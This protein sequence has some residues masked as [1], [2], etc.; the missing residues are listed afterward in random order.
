[1]N[2]APPSRIYNS[3]KV[4]KPPT[5]GVPLDGAENAKNT[6]GMYVSGGSQIG[7]KFKSI[8]NIYGD[9]ISGSGLYLRNV[10]SWEYF[11]LDERTDIFRE[12]GNVSIGFDNTNHKL[13][14]NGSMIVTDKITTTGFQHPSLMT[15]RT[16][17][18]IYLRIDGNTSSVSFNTDYPDLNAYLTVNNTV[19]THNLL[20][21]DNLVITGT[22]TNINTENMNI[23]DPVVLVHEAHTGKP[24]KDAGYIVDRSISN[25]NVGMI[26]DELNDRFMFIYTNSTG[27][28]LNDINIPIDKYA[29]LH[30]NE[31]NADVNVTAINFIGNG[32]QIG[33]VHQEISKQYNVTDDGNSLVL[34]KVSQPILTLVRGVQYLF[35][36]NTN[37]VFFFSTQNNNDL[38]NKYTNGITELSE[39]NRILFDIPCDAPNLLYYQSNTNLNFGNKIEFIDSKLISNDRETY[40]DIENN[41]I[42]FYTNNLSRMI[43]PNTNLIGINNDNPQEKLDLDG[44]LIAN[45]NIRISTNVYQNL[46]SEILYWNDTFVNDI[47]IT[48]GTFFKGN[49][50]IYNN[51]NDENVINVSITN[52][53]RI[54]TSEIF[55]N[56]NGSFINLNKWHGESSIYKLHDRVG[57]G[58]TDPLS[59]LN[60]LGDT[61]ITN[62]THTNL[63]ILNNVTLKNPAWEYIVD[64]VSSINDISY[65]YGRVGIKTSTPSEKLEVCGTIQTGYFVGNAT[66]M[67][68][69]PITKW[70]GLT[71]IYYMNGNI[72]IGTNMPLTDLD[73]NGGI[74][75]GNSSSI[76]PITGTIRWNQE[77]MRY[78]GYGNNGWIDLTD[79]GIL[80]DN[81]IWIK[82]D[83]KVLHTNSSVSI[84]TNVSTENLT[85]YGNLSISSILTLRGTDII[86]NTSELNVLDGI[87]VTTENLNLM[88]GVTSSTQELNYLNGSE[89]GYASAN[90][91]LIPDKDLNINMRNGSL[92][93]CD[94]IITSN[95]SLLNTSALLIVNEIGVNDSIITLGFDSNNNTSDAGFIIETGI[96]MSNKV[97]VW[98]ESAS[99]FILASTLCNST[100]ETIIIENYMDLHV[101]NTIVN[102]SIIAHDFIGDGYNLTNIIPE[103]F[104]IFTVTE[105]N[106]VFEINGIAQQ[107]ITLI[108]GQRYKFDV[109][110]ITES[111]VITNDIDD[112]YLN[113]IIGS[114]NNQYSDPPEL[115]FNIHSG[116]AYGDLYYQSQST[117][118]MGGKIHISNSDIHS[119][120]GITSVGIKS[121]NIIEFIANNSNIMTIN[122]FGFIGINTSYPKHQLD[123]QGGNLK[124]DG[125]I[126]P[127]V[128][129]TYNIGNETLY[130]D[131]AYINDLTL[132][133][134]SLYMNNKVVISTNSNN[135]L[136]LTVDEI[137]THQAEVENVLSSVNNEIVRINKWRGN[138]SIHFLDGNVGIGTKFPNEL[139]NI[140]G[141]M[142]IFGDINSSRIIVDNTVIKVPSWTNNVN[143]SIYYNNT[144]VGINNENPN[145]ELDIGGN[146]SATYL[147]GDGSNLLD[148]PVSKWIGI[149]DLYY[150]GNI[151]IGYITNTSERLTING[152]LHI[153][154]SFSILNGSLRYS[155]D[156]YQ[157][158]I[159]NSYI[160]FL[161][162]NNNQI[163]VNKW[164]K[165]P[166]TDDIYFLGNVGFGT[167]N[168]QHSIDIDGNM[169]IE[170]NLTLN[171]NLLTASSIDLNKLDGLLSSIDELN[172][173]TNI[174]TITSEFNTLI[175][176]TSG[177]AIPNKIIIVDENKNV[178]LDKGSVTVGNLIVQNNMTINGNSTTLYSNN[179]LI[180]DTMFVLSKQQVGIPVRDSG[181]IVNRSSTMNVGLIWDEDQNEFAFIKTSDPNILNNNNIIIDEYANLHINNANI[182]T[183]ITAQNFFGNGSQLTGFV[184][185]WIGIDDIYYNNGNV[186]INTDQTS[187]TVSL[188]G[189]FLLTNDLTESETTLRIASLDHNLMLINGTTGNIGF[190]ISNPKFK[191]D[192]N[193]TVRVTD[194][195]LIGNHS[196]TEALIDIFIDNDIK[197]NINIHSDTKPIFFVNSTTRNIGINNYNPLNTLDIIGNIS[198]TNKLSVNTWI[199]NDSLTINGT[200]RGDI[201]LGNGSGISHVIWKDDIDNGVIYLTDKYNNLSDGNVGINTTIPLHKL[202]ISGDITATNF[203][204]NGSLLVNPAG[205]WSK[206]K[207]ISYLGGNV[208][209]GVSIPKYRL[210]IDGVVNATSLV[211]DGSQLVGLPSNRWIPINTDIYYIGNVVI[212]SDIGKDVLYVN[213][214]TKVSGNNNIFNLQ[215]KTVNRVTELL[216]VNGTTNSVSIMKGIPQYTLDINGSMYSNGFIVGNNI[217]H[218]ATLDIIIDDIDVLQNVSIRSNESVIFKLDTETG[219]IGI[220]K[221]NPLDILDIYGNVSITD[222]LIVNVSIPNLI[223]TV[224]VGGI[225]N[226]TEFMGNGSLLTGLIWTDNSNSGFI[227]IINKSELL[228]FGNVGI[229]T[230]TPQEILD[231]NGITTA[232]LFIGNGSLLTNIPN[233]WIKESPIKYISNISITNS[234]VGIGTDT[235]NSQLEV[236][237]SVNAVKY[238]GDGSQLI[239][240]SGTKW[241]KQDPSS[242]ESD[243]YYIGNINLGDTTDSD[244]NLIVNGSVTITY[245]INDNRATNVFE[246]SLINTEKLFVINEKT[247]NVGINEEIPL[248]TLDVNNSIKASNMLIG[249]HTDSEA[250]LDIDINTNYHIQSLQ[251]TVRTSLLFVDTVN[252]RVGVN[253][254]TPLH[255]LDVS[256]NVISTGIY[257]NV[258][259][260]NSMEEVQVVGSVNATYIIGNGSQLTGMSWRENNGLLYFS[261]RSDNLSNGNIG[262]GTTNPLERLEVIGTITATDFISNGAYLSYVNNKW[263]HKSNNY[264]TDIFYNIGG[265]VGIKTDTPTVDFEVAGDVSGTI[266]IGDGSGLTSIGST[267]IWVKKQE[268]PVTDIYYTGGSIS[269]GVNSTKSDFVVNGS[270]ILEI[271]PDDLVYGDDRVLNINTRLSTNNEIYKSIFL[272]NATSRNIGV[273]VL[274]PL[275]KL[276]INDNLQTNKLFVGNND[277]TVGI[278]DIY[279]DTD[280]DVFQDVQF[281]KSVSDVNSSI[282]YV[283][284]STHRV[285]ICNDTPQYELDVTGDVN[286][287]GQLLVNTTD[288]SGD[289]LQVSGIVNAS[290]LVGD[291]SKVENLIWSNKSTIFPVTSYGTFTNTRIG[292]GTLTPEVELDVFGTIKATNIFGDGSNLTDT[293][294]VYWIKNNNDLYCNATLFNGQ[295]RGCSVGIGNSSPTE[296][297]DVTGTVNA[298]SFIGDGSQLTNLNS[299]TIWT[300]ETVD[301]QVNLRYISPIKVGN[302]QNNLNNNL[303]SELTT[304]SLARKF[305]SL[306]STDS[307]YMVAGGESINQVD[308][309]DGTNW[310]QTTLSS[311]RGLTTSAAFDNKIYII[312]GTT[313]SNEIDM[314]DAITGEWST[315]TTLANGRERATSAAVNNYLLVAGGVTSGGNTNNVEIYNIPTG[316]WTYATLAQGPE[317]SY[318]SETLANKIYITGGGTAVSNLVDIYDTDTNTWSI[319]TFATDRRRQSIGSA[320]PY[321]MFA[322]GFNPSATNLIDI[323]NDITNEWTQSTL[324][325][326]KYYLFAGGSNNKIMF[327]PGTGEET[328]VEIF[329]TITGQWSVTSVGTARHTWGSTKNIGIIKSDYDY[330]FILGGGE[331][332]T[333]GVN[334]VD[335]F[336]FPITVQ[337]STVTVGGDAHFYAD[338][339]DLIIND[340]IPDKDTRYVYDTTSF[341]YSAST[342]SNR[343]RN[344][345]V[346][347]V[348][349]KAYFIGG[350][351]E[352][353]NTLNSID[354]Y[355]GNT[356]TWTI[357]SLV[358]ERYNHTSVAVGTLI[359]TAGGNNIGTVINN[360]EI[361]D[362]TT[363][364]AT[365]LSTLS[366]L[367]E[368][369]ASTTAGDYIL[370]GADATNHVDIYNYVTNTWY[371]STITVSLIS[372]SII[373]LESKVYFD[374][375]NGSNEVNV[376]D[377]DI[378][379]WSVTTVSISAQY[380]TF[381]TCDDHLFLAAGS[382]AI[383]RN[384]V[385]I[386]NSATDVWSVA[387]LSEIKR[388]VVTGGISNIAMFAGGYDGD[389]TNSVD[390]FNTNTSV[391]SQT[392]LGTPI[393]K[394]PNRI[395]AT[396]RLANNNVKFISGGGT[397]VSTTN[398]VDIFEFNV[399][400]PPIIPTDPEP[401]D[402]STYNLEYTTMSVAHKGLASTS[403]G[404]KSYFIG[405]KNAAATNHNIVDIYDSDT[406]IWTQTTILTARYQHT[407]VAHGTNIYIA[408]GD[409]T[410]NIEVFDT[411]TLNSVSFSTLSGVRKQLAS[412]TTGDYIVFGGGGS[413][414]NH[415]EIYNVITDTWIQSTLTQN[416]WRADATT[417]G[418]KIYFAP[419]DSSNQTDIFDTNDLSFSQATIS[420]LAGETSIMSAFPYVMYTGAFSGGE[421]HNKIDIYNTSTNI[422]SVL[423]L[424]TKRKRLQVGGFTNIFMFAGGDSPSADNTIDIYDVENDIWSF[425]T[426]QIGTSYISD[427]NIETVRMTNTNVKF[428]LAGGNSTADELNNVEIYE[429]TEI[430]APVPYVPIVLDKMYD[431]TLITYKYTTL[432][433][434]RKELATATVGNTSYFIGGRDGGAAITN[435]IDIYDGY[436]NVW[437]HTTM[438]T[439]RYSHSAIA[440]GTDIYIAGG[441]DGVDTNNIEIFDTLTNTGTNFSTLSGAKIQFNAA[442]TGNYILFGGGGGGSFGNHI[443]IF[444]VLTNT[445]TQATI[446]V[447]EFRSDSIGF[448]NKIYYSSTGSTNEI[449]IFDTDTV[450]WSL[451]TTSIVTG[452]RSLAAT[453]THLFIAGGLNSSIYYNEVDIYNSVTDTWSVDTLSF[454]RRLISSGGLHNIVV[455]AGGEDAI[456]T[457]ALDIYN[458][459]TSTWITSTLDAAISHIGERKIETVKTSSGNL[460]F[461][462]GGGATAV[463]NVNI[464]D[465]PEIVPIIP[466]IPTDP[467][468]LDISTYNLEYTTMS[469]A[470]KGLAS[471]SV[472][473]KSYFIGGKNAAA[474]NHNI[475][476]IYDSDTN[477]WTQTTILT[478]RYQHTAVA[479][480][481]NIYIA[482]G[483]APSATNDVEV[484]DTLTLNSVS[485]STLSG[486]RKQLASATTGD[487]IVFGG[488]G[489]PGNHAEIY[490]VI[491]DTWTQSTLT[492]NIWRADA[493]ALGT[494]VY[495]IP[496]DESNQIDILD[497]TDLSWTQNT[498]SILSGTTS[499]TSASP[500]LMYAGAFAQ[501]ARHNNIDIYNSDTDTWSLLTLSTKRNQIK[502]GAFT[503]IFMFAG[504]I[505]SVQSNNIEIYD[506]VNNIWSITTLRTPTNNISD[507]NIETVRMTN[508]NVKFI[509]AGGHSSSD[510]LNNVE[511]YEFS[512][513]VAPIPLPDAY[514]ET[515]ISHTTST[516]S[517]T[518]TK[519]AISNIGSKIYF[520]G[521]S[522]VSATKLNIIDIYDGDTDT[523][524]STTMTSERNG[525]VSLAVGTNIYIAGGQLTSGYANIVEIFDTNTITSTT[526][527]TLTIGRMNLTAGKV[528]DYLVFAGGFVAGTSN[529]VDLYNYN[530]D[531]WTTSTITV[532]S[533]YMA[534]AVIEPNMYILPNSGNKVDIF[535]ATSN[536]WS[537]ATL[538]ITGTYRSVSATDTHLLVAGGVSGSETNIIDIYDSVNNIWSTSTLNNPRKQAMSIGFSNLAIIAGGYNGGGVNDIDIYNS[539]TN[540]WIQSTLEVGKY[541]FGNRYMGVIIVGLDIKFITAGGFT[542]ITNHVEIFTF[543]ES[544]TVTPTILPPLDLDTSTFTHTLSTLLISRKELASVS[545]NGKA[546]YFG[547]RSAA[548]IAINNIDIYDADTNSWI[549]KELNTKRYSH[550][551][552]VHSTNIYIA[553]GLDGPSLNSVEIYDTITGIVTEFSTLSV[554]HK[555]LGSASAGDYVLFGG[556]GNNGNHVDIYNAVTNIWTQSTLTNAVWRSSAGSLGSKIYFHSKD[557]DNRIEIFETTDQTWSIT[558]VPSI[559]GTRTIASTGPYLM[560][561]GG[562]SGSK[563][564]DIDIFNS[565]T[566]LWT[567]S[568]LSEAKTRPMGGGFSN[569]IM[570]AGGF[571]TSASNSVDIFNTNTGIWIQTTLNTGL[572]RLSD[573]KIETV[574]LSNTNIQFLV[575]GGTITSPAVNNLNIFEFQPII[576]KITTIGSNTNIFSVIQTNTTHLNHLF[577]TDIANN[578][579]GISQGQPT[580]KL[581]IGSGNLLITNG[582]FI[583]NNTVMNIPDYVFE[584]DYSLMSLDKLQTFIQQYKHLP[585]IPDRYDIK[586]NGININNFN[587]KLLEKT[588]ELVLYTLQQHDILNNL[589]NN[590]NQYDTQ[591]TELENQQQ[592]ISFRIYNL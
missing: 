280:H 310:T 212:N 150:D 265:D 256:G 16:N 571:S 312:G 464:F 257:V 492:Q 332:T 200:F 542:P 328:N 305:T 151:S 323:Y 60:V 53:F 483:D 375:I 260:P 583:V 154:N 468:P 405:G 538:T 175:G 543:Q 148:L 334:N 535:N 541:K 38:L 450:T 143:G 319:A 342:L 471:T 559:A 261:N 400:T 54:N 557:N 556:G 235:P 136:V 501:G 402:I 473:T 528:G 506:V 292:I 267:G 119:G 345:S 417:V 475:V 349:N 278:L 561:A 508:T 199:N 266:L 98:D 72:G 122:Q 182:N 588:E 230:T 92:T 384:T 117:P 66:F 532:A 333:T 100:K 452:T 217:I 1:M 245:D 478:A 81:N 574:Q 111:F 214:S 330:K 490:N 22:N 446:S 156:D 52:N 426:L 183:S 123:I 379:V 554:T 429:F 75:I 572:S 525:P 373:A 486:V 201:L 569:V 108:R 67:D 585:N 153:G 163:D 366:G 352:V 142:G 441:N 166:I 179:L 286:I 30:L 236:V 255:T 509:V 241:T 566:G 481:T 271:N 298:I 337:P 299:N 39:P 549:A 340:G 218:E 335:I 158:F 219:Y 459:N 440:Y 421:H 547:G 211:G 104:R 301:T 493:T 220:N 336:R 249:D 141:N 404:I 480:G 205:L 454:K 315:P 378:E 160:S 93:V 463:N 116:N 187:S 548:S 190:G 439:G 6:A 321:I 159:N 242:R 497:T 462:F 592:N 387:T 430:A 253:N 168:P 414:G 445:W 458:T 17:E 297:V 326:T 206:N 244:E 174:T 546:Y 250:I 161:D 207:D 460:Q 2:I 415:I 51:E 233:L 393:L 164:S 37:E 389:S 457:N 431:T 8:G 577:T 288:I 47:Y 327:G 423:T 576:N 3:L 380:R 24:I 425:T 178:N 555:Q 329:D 418:T 520:S 213:G 573:R 372:P 169:L 45:G 137:R 485:F 370:F 359:Y 545:L 295:I 27:I 71:D 474:T 223:E 14:I 519:M 579:V 320:Y 516:L 181:F 69:L 149:S 567:A 131:I 338:K 363:N 103:Y 87:I 11:D 456:L 115:I 134:N 383:Y 155:G 167:N 318:D 534:S 12:I 188:N 120:N 82:R 517:T 281:R 436:N 21:N 479:H 302:Y 461:I 512:E 306:V 472:G 591:I 354:I 20:V 65:N 42:N 416:I 32:T 303:T 238:S 229:N 294:S 419:Q 448:K 344:L 70:N 228:S 296:A 224:Q 521:G 408:G 562:E 331:V 510:E 382:D 403:V 29:P 307:I 511:I 388:V 369:L 530:T 544:N 272:V 94:M 43:I 126:Y 581:D 290:F 487:Y 453:T 590:N 78:E 371:Q 216:S 191:F 97:F 114:G 76:I 259:T 381:T 287:D 515:I 437:S 438:V 407:A 165:S 128:N 96:G 89:F 254:S 264:E 275:V 399:I 36:I 364:I 246:L 215:T 420:F 58:R 355:D 447:A 350:F 248:F 23:F 145:F 139:L 551:A 358:T 101:N 317:E 147:L 526:F 226:A 411:L 202:D 392:T 489:S 494:K 251:S 113:G 395:I 252:D 180:S 203:I 31:L 523:W 285:G 536:T 582:E 189:S 550:T 172:V 347:S 491:T 362:T 365:S 129:N 500:Y 146:L 61:T 83:N 540:V 482:G 221:D 348:G 443:D 470:H 339:D 316:V 580:H 467:E 385:D 322:G 377:T 539:D 63:V 73:V 276:H 268:D 476:D 144:F 118:N 232:E 125:N 367:Y 284:S 186:S 88:K 374:T 360:V 171:N 531:T 25:R 28:N 533:E 518:R 398:E 198:L 503:N 396:I 262:I 343:K 524:S 433:T 537:A 324:T 442:T 409:A 575:G 507:R 428:I 86:V 376:Y 227:S 570:F 195:I 234:F 502:V 422:W 184:N 208:G 353:G 26:W 587:M 193:N 308:I 130:W 273:G 62:M 300:E 553:G 269:V 435:T 586:T 449:N 231:I 293:G 465:F 514:D 274:D 15:F 140:E 57:I 132:S 304:L 84:G 135:E 102:N 152:S 283:D 413:P 279:V 498:L 222:Q 263:T 277:N 124:I 529:Q 589:L 112:I 99:E 9:K 13:D 469:V 64:P 243:I 157:G 44:N 237:G 424:S 10:S 90:R 197:T 79:T 499:V 59:E 432:A 127:G 85:V 412:A 194:G 48:N 565:D 170:G 313:N 33:A 34:D 138:S 558:T 40:I 109:S 4:I 564:N 41:I 209:I 35:H 466:I 105:N 291:M 584:S 434:F 196:S 204:A 390:I 397:A 527:S 504:G 451:A 351:D 5:N 496:Q 7:K 410:N 513:I 95:V 247:H 341:T 107:S 406:N 391:W 80:N 210:D 522:D 173:L 110:N 484:F 309:Y 386:Y 162:E 289:E 56:E 314:Y 68:N 50:V 106:N 455:F 18:S 368:K 55:I 185:K 91:A 568:T 133:N 239:N 361:F 282:L 192:T 46:G 394:T 477:I 427:R 505:H 552:V 311:A 444:N 560:I 357:S 176:L 19:I 495:F 258:T 356:D 488:G 77:Y 563:F 49:R 240:L 325:G 121:D 270:V 225:I 177:K 74:N 578:F 401:L 346:V